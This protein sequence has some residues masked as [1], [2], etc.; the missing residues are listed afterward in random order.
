MGRHGRPAPALPAA[1]YVP[2]KIYKGLTWRSS[3]PSEDQEGTKG[4]SRGGREGGKDRN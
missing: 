3:S 2:H 4:E 1:A